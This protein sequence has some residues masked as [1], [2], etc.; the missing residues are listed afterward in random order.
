M[1][2]YRDVWIRREVGDGVFLNVSIPDK[3]PVGTHVCLPMSI[4]TESEKDLAWE[5]EEALGTA[6]PDLISWAFNLGYESGVKSV[7]E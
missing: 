1:I 4:E 3:D 7:S 5:I 6:T 2:D